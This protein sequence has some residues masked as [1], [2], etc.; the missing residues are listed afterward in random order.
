GCKPVPRGEGADLATTACCLHQRG[1]PERLSHGPIVR[2][3]CVVI[4]G[5]AGCAAQPEPDPA[6]ASPT[7]EEF[8]QAWG[9]P[10]AGSTARPSSVPLASGPAPLA[11]IMERPG[12]VTVSDSA[13]RT[14]G[15]VAV[16]AR[17]IVRVAEPT[18]VAVGST[19]LDRGP[20]PPGLTYTISSDVPPD[21]GWRNGQLPTATPSVRSAGQ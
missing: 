3:A 1:F 17:T 19:R 21:T 20:L 18:G 16:G 5:V 7:R 4:S 11:Y 8:I 9:G 6:A 12:S 2:V 13:G 10:A 15:P 14:W